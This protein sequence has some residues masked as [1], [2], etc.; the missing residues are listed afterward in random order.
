MESVM[1]DVYLA[2]V[3]AIEAGENVHPYWAWIEYP[4]LKNRQINS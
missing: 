4:N 3:V 2:A 1:N